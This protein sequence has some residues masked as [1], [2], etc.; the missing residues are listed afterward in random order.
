MIQGNKI[1]DTIPNYKNVI[2]GRLKNGI[3]KKS[4]IW[5]MCNIPYWQE[6]M[7]YKP[8]VEKLQA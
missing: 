1:I 7:Y 5:K 4:L 2:L 3:V 8:Q 6:L